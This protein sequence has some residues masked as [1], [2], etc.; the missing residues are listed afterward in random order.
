MNIEAN[1]IEESSPN[2]ETQKAMEDVQMK[3]GTKVKNANDLFTKLKIG[4]H[5]DLF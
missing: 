3:K 1:V 2:Y 4:T 5:A